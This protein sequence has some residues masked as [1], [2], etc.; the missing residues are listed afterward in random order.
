MSSIC[1]VVPTIRFNT[2]VWKTF[3]EAW[4]PLFKKHN[5]NLIVIEDSENPRAHIKAA[6][7]EMS[8]VVFLNEFPDLDGLIQRFSPAVRNFGFYLAAKLFPETEHIVTL[9]DDTLPF[10]DTIGD[11]IHILKN[12]GLSYPYWNTF[13][14]DTPYYPRGFPY[15]NRGAV[16]VV[17]SHG[18]WHGVKDWDAMTQLV[19]GNPDVSFYK[20]PVPW[21]FYMPVCGMNLAFSIRA[22]PYVYYAPAKQIK[23][24]ERF[25]D[26]WMGYVLQKELEA[27]QLG[28]VSGFAAVLHERASDVYKNLCQEYAGVAMNETFVQEARS[29]TFWYADLYERWKGLFL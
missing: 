17:V 3:L 2:P 23:G 4:E 19:L 7:S 12:G 26:I 20:G 29:G 6:F 10:E 28:M 15:H 5:V 1:V 8:A 18:I 13:S 25:D 24:A 11:H 9:D 21:G 22:L 16:P 27:Q 14:A